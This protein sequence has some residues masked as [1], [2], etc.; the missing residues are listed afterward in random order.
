M[1]FRVLELQPEIVTL[2]QE[3][4]EDAVA[5]LC[6]AF[7]DYP[8][9]RFVLGDAGDRPRRMRRLIEFFTMARFLRGEPVLGAQLDSKLVAVALISFP[10]VSTSPRKLD[11]LRESVWSELGSDARARYKAFNVAN[12]PFEVD[13]PHAHLNMI[14]VRHA[15]HGTGLGRR[16][17]AEVHRIATA[18]ARCEGVTL[19]TESPANVRFYERLGYRE[20]GRATVAETLVTWALFRPN[21][22]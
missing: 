18:R 15:F 5:V 20:I 4:A 9:M 19:S 10:G 7:A 16:L 12:E 2:G 8:V 1:P 6:D 21:A 14:G 3:N 17:M 11:E 22:V 13:V